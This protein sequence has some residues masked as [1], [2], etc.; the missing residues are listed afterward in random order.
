MVLVTNEN[1]G[2]DVE[3]KGDKCRNR[4][5][6]YDRMVCSAIQTLVNRKQKSQNRHGKPY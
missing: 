4:F 5:S 3:K 2:K 1:L 6:G